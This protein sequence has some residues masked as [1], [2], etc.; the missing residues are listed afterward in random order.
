M[1][2]LENKELRLKQIVHLVNQRQKIATTELA[3]LLQVSEMTIRR[4]LDLLQKSGSIQRI[5]G[6]AAVPENAGRVEVSSEPDAYDFCLASTQYIREKEK[7]AKY[8]A[9]LIEPDDWVFMDNGTTT[10]RLAAFFPTHFKFTALCS[11]VA[12]LTGI[13]KYPNIHLVMPGGSYDRT[14]QTF[15]SQQA[16]DF[17]RTLRANKVFLSASGV[18]KT[19]GITCIN[20]H[21]SFNKRAFIESSA[22]RI[23]LVDSSKFGIVKANHFAELN[24]IDMIITDS[25]LDS[26]WKK[27]LEQIGIDVRIVS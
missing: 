10:A 12:L 9:S 11:N 2:R 17:I 25:G 4:D 24:E 3:E 26:S 18:H 5:H 8:A 16:D 19:L 27:Y 7:I 22:E 13:L 15:S 6:Y 1:G 21:S 23:L 14:D 20:A